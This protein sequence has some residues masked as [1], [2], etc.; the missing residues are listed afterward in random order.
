MARNTPSRVPA[1]ARQASSRSAGARRPA[2]IAR[3]AATAVRSAGS[4]MDNLPFCV[5]P[6][7][8]RPAFRGH[9]PRMSERAQSLVRVIQANDG[10]VTYLVGVGPESLPPVRSADLAHAWEAARQAARGA[11]WGLPR[12][13]RFLQE[14]GRTIDL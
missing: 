14:D 9:L 2:S 10:S 5:P 11:E 4:P 1:R 6:R 3:A 8:A 13:F 12:A 7:L